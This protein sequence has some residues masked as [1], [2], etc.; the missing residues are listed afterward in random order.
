MQ[1]NRYILEHPEV[2]DMRST[3]ALMEN[4]IVEV[5]SSKCDQIDLGAI[6]YK[7]Q[8]WTSLVRTYLGP[9][10][11]KELTTVGVG[12]SGLSCG[13]DFQRKKSHNGSCLRE[14]IVSRPKRKGYPWTTV[15]VFWRTAE[16]QR[17]WAADLVLIHR[18]IELIPNCKPE[19]IILV[20]ATAQHTAAYITPVIEPVLGLKFDKLNAAHPYI[21]TVLKMK[22]TYYDIGAPKWC[23]LLS[24][25]IALH[26][27]YQRGER[28]KPLMVSDCELEVE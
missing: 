28:P 5:K 12:T 20:M 7:H 14:V 21:K 3:M 4:V 2:T 19:R 6:G 27:M 26:Q 11:I 9:L 10:K 13:F 18:M 24:R 8:K 17:R 25:S 16:L 23:K 22:K 15:T 1:L